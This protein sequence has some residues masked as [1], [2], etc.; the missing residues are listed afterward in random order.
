MKVVVSTPSF[1]NSTQHPLLNRKYEKKVLQWEGA[2]RFLSW[3]LGGRVEGV[4]VPSAE[5]QRRIDHRRTSGTR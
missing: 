4:T 5:K 1:S 3:I 2:S